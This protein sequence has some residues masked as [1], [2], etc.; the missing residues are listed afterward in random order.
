MNQLT[1]LRMKTYWLSKSILD[2]F[3]VVLISVKASV[4]TLSIR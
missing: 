3:A 4:I 1:L 2:V